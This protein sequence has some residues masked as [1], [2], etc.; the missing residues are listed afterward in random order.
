MVVFGAKGRWFESHS[1][2]HILLLLLAVSL[3]TATANFNVDMISFQAQAI[4]AQADKKQRQFDKT[5]DEWKRKVADLQTELET[6]LRD[7]R[8]NAAEVY[9][10]RAQLEEA[11]EAIEALRRENKNLT[12]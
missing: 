2:R 5:I 1:S 9:K 6:A 4:A 8:A 11:S 10:L 12:G 3:C 7:G